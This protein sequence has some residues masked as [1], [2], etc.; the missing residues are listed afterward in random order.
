MNSE[1]LLALADNFLIFSIFNVLIM[2]DSSALIFSFLYLQDMIPFWTPF[3][4]TFF[5]LLAIDIFYYSLGRSTLFEKILKI[6]FLKRFFKNVDDVLH[7]IAGKNLFISLIIA[8][9]TSGAKVF[10]LIALGKRKGSFT[11]FL[12]TD[13]L[14]TLLWMF[15]MFFLGYL[16][17]LGFTW[18]VDLIGSVSLGLLFL[19]IVISIII[20]KNKKVKKYLYRKFKN[21]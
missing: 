9:I 12:L 7:L 8:K 17:N 18:I 6:K 5:L 19:G 10:A 3:L 13:F 20:H 14:T 21:Q 1:I 4:I 11:K 16:V 15:A 2:G